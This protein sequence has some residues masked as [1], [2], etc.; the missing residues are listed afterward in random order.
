MHPLSLVGC[1]RQIDAVKMICS[2]PL[3]LRN[4]GNDPR[5]LHTVL[6]SHRHPET[7]I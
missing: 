6:A 3:T 4:P 1:P 5:R 2:A 7:S